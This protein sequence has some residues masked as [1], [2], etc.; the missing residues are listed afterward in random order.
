V[1]PLNGVN[2]VVFSAAAPEHAPMRIEN[3]TVA[4]AIRVT[5]RGTQLWRECAPMTEQVRV[6]GGDYGLTNPAEPFR[7]GKPQL[8]TAALRVFYAFLSAA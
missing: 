2:Y 8:A 6:G 5:Q 1:R 3:A 7:S 4:D